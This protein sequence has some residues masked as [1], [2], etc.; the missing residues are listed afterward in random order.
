MRIDEILITTAT[1]T[2]LLTTDG[3]KHY[4]INHQSINQSINHTDFFSLAKKF[5]RRRCERTTP[6]DLKP[7]ENW[8]IKNE[9]KE[10]LLKGIVLSK[11]YIDCYL[12]QEK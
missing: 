7:A 10:V 1:T 12:L 3:V 5:L 9:K 4:S 8:R 6:N 2:L 11:I